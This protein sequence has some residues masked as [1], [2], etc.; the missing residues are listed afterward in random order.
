MWHRNRTPHSQDQEIEGEIEDDEQSAGINVDEQQAE[1]Q[2]V[3]TCKS[4]LAEEASALADM[5]DDERF[6]TS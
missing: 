4:L 1:L 2:W 6:L 5:S 3:L